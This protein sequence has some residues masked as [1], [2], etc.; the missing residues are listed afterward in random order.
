[1]EIFRFFHLQTITV[2]YLTLSDTLAQSQRR[3][4]PLVGNPTD[5]FVCLF[6]VCF[7]FLFFFASNNNPIILSWVNQQ[8]LPTILVNLIGY[9]TYHL[10]CVR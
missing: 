6:F 8:K 10:F 7:C 9:A 3:A 2:T 4:W 5:F 1:M